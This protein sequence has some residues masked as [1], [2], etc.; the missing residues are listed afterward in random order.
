VYS[1]DPEFPGDVEE[2]Y[3]K[4]ADDTAFIMQHSITLSAEKA[5]P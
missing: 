2:L 5:P 3:C 1:G 4:D